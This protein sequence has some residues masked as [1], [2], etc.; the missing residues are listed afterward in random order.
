MVAATGC[1]DRRVRV[2]QEL[3][4]GEQMVAQ[5]REQAHRRVRFI[6]LAAGER[7][8][9]SQLARDAAI[10]SAVAFRGWDFPH[11]QRNREH[12]GN[13]PVPNGWESWTRFFELE[14]WRILRS[15]QFVHLATLS[16]DGS[17]WAGKQEA[18]PFLDLE[19]VVY[20]FTE[21]FVFAGRLMEKA[22]YGVTRLEIAYHSIAQREITTSPLRLLHEGYRSAQPSA[23]V[24]REMSASSSPEEEARSAAGEFLLAFGLELRDGVI[25]SIQSQLLEGRL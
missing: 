25:A 23:V 1:G 11:F 14:A 2:T 3:T 10:A 13:G 18:K 7:F 24:S 20:E 16:E 9:Q 12:G 6:P 17:A 19:N 21:F 8:S 15:G 5:I 4:G 22:D